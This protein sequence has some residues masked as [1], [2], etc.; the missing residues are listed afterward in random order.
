MIEIYLYFVYTG[1]FFLSDSLVCFR[2]AVDWFLKGMSQPVLL[3]WYMW[4][5]VCIN[6]FTASVNLV[7]M[8]SEVEWVLLCLVRDWLQNVCAHRLCN[9]EWEWVSLQKLKLWLMHSWVKANGL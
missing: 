9:C 7:V 8:V 6:L 5:Y 3:M 2:T 4:K 1:D